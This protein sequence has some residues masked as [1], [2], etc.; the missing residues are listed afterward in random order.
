MKAFFDLADQSGD[1]MITREK[2]R[3]VMASP[4]TKQWFAAQGLSIRDPDEV[5][6]LLDADGSET[7]TFF[8]PQC[9]ILLFFVWICMV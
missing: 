1:T 7:W 8:L 5:F 6:T 9:V 3:V 4:S 2:W